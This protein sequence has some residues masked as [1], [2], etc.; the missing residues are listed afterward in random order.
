MATRTEKAFNT[1]KITLSEPPKQIVSVTSKS[2]GKAFGS[3]ILDYSIEDITLVFKKRF[4]EITVV[5]ES[6]I[7][8]EQ[9]LAAQKQFLN[10]NLGKSITGRIVPSLK[11]TAAKAQ[12]KQAALSQSEL[13]KTLGSRASGF[14]TIAE[15]FR[16][17]ITTS[18]EPIPA[19]L[20]DN[21]SDKIQVKK[22]SL[23]KGA[24]GI[25]TGKT[26]AD[27]FLNAT[28]G[29]SDPEG[30]KATLEELDELTTPIAS[31]LEEVLS[32][33]SSLPNL[34]SDAVNN[35]PITEINTST[36]N[37]SKEIDR[38]LGNPISKP[39]SSF[40]NLLV[41]ALNTAKNEAPV[42]G[43]K[44]TITS[45]K[46]DA[47]GNTVN[48]NLSD[49]DANTSLSEAISNRQLIPDLPSTVD[50]FSIEENGF[51]W[52][53]AFTN[54]DAYKF[55]TVD[56]VEELELEL[57]N[58]R[59]ELTG[60][61]IHWSRSHSDQ[62]LT[63][64]DIHLRHIE[65]AKRQL[66]NNYSRFA[67]E[68]GIGWHY[69]IQR[70]GT[71]Q[72]GRPISKSGL[73]GTA[74]AKRAIHIGFIAGYNS[75]VGTPNFE[76]TLSSASITEKQWESFELTLKT[77][78]KVYPGMS[79]V[80]HN[81]VNPT[82]SCPGFNVIQY[83]ESNFGKS[84]VYDNISKYAEAFTNEEQVNRLSKKIIKET[85]PLQG[86]LQNIAESLKN[87]FEQ[88]DPVTG[89]LKVRSPAELLK[90][91]ENY[92]EF[93]SKSLQLGKSIEQTVN[94][95]IGKTGLDDK[96]R[97]AANAIKQSLEGELKIAE[98]AALESRKN[99]I[100]SGKI[101]NNSTWEDLQ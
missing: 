32:P 26:S 9:E 19:I 69:V 50:V 5:Y 70:D 86:P 60:A 64:T 83:T 97:D 71:I 23:F 29:S 4:D 66:G 39:G 48:F 38:R 96:L 44:Q 63:A 80:G 95:A 67:K 87:K 89:E 56:T 30:L 57:S 49:A 74:W 1:N 17:N 7:L 73:T 37:A 93:K 35:D 34:I 59:R 14:Q 90:D 2:S 88:T 8:T 41:S 47:N 101:Y 46:I 42:R 40:M 25:F 79:V 98:D 36:S 24:I 16:E 91:A 13:A 52:S 20:K 62:F 6:S 11:A 61:V 85:E 12:S 58:V 28:V 76:Q 81:D 55:E 33:L 15:D 10:S 82:S 53:G 78:Y 27:G 84:V 99:L 77:I 54:L 100:N 18:D 92:E 3:K 45:K 51:K 43:L 68:A 75:P 21:P 65:L 22:N 31:D 72:R 94:D